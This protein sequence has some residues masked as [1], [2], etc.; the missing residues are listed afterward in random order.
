MSNN[1]LQL[2]L[3]RL[4]LGLSAACALHCLLAPVAL[5]TLPV[6]AGSVLADEH[7]HQVLLLLVLPASVVALALGCRR[8]KDTRVLALG[9]MGLSILVLTA[10]LG[11]DLAGKLGEKLMTVAGALAL[12]TGHARNY[13]LC[14]R[15]SCGH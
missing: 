12:S 1:G 7:F 8:H 14:R 6:L 9:A 5:V 13:R 4:A 15:S 3:D 2:V 11:H 10:A